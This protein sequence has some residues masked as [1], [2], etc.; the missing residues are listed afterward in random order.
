MKKL[1]FSLV[2]VS[3]LAVNSH[4]LSGLDYNVNVT[5]YPITEVA[6]MA[7][8]ITGNVNIEQVYFSNSS[9]STAQTV[10]IYSLC[11]STITVTLEYRVYIPAGDINNSVKLDFP[12]FNTP[13]AL[14]DVCF[15]KSSAESSVH[16][17]VHYR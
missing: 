8:E 15:R 6:F 1:L 10:S 11:D 16:V 3:V 2:L 14:H 7:T 4:A 17:N 12:L 13:F 9:T 5:S